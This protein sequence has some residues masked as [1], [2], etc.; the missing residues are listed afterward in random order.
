MTQAAAARRRDGRTL[1]GPHGMDGAAL[2]NTRFQPPSA[3]DSRRN[4]R[5]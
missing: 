1:Q 2:V 5:S 3:L 4:N